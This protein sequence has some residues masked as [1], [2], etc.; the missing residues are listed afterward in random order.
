MSKLQFVKQVAETLEELIEFFSTMKAEDHF[1]EEIEHNQKLINYYE[2]NFR[3]IK[4]RIAEDIKIDNVD[5]DGNNVQVSSG[6]LFKVAL[7]VLCMRDLADRISTEIEHS[8]G[9][10]ENVMIKID[11]VMEAYGEMDIYRLSSIPDPAPLDPKQQEYEN[12]M[13]KPRIN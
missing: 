6:S 8:E 10:I 5:S 11:D 3:A 7:A 1:E 12:P 13:K 4:E 2:Y 9:I